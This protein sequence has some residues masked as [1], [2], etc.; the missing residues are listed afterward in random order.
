MKLP[1]NVKA[2][3]STLGKA[4]NTMKWEK[5]RTHQHARKLIEMKNTGKIQSK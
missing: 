1:L 2:G 5:N 3:R 4:Q